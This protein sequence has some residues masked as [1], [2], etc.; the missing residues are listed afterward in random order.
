[1]VTMTSKITSLTI[2]YSIVYSKADQSKHQSPASLAFVR[3]IHRWP[4]NSPHKGPVT[5]RMFPFDY[6]IMYNYSH[7]LLHVYLHAAPIWTARNWKR[8]FWK[9]LVIQIC[10]SPILSSV[11]LI[12]F[13]YIRGTSHAYPDS[14]VHEANM[15][16][17]WGRQDPG[18]S[19][20]G[21]VKLA[22]WVIFIWY[23]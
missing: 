20:V 13:Y 21:H 10:Y 6:V 7:T 23:C 5:Q 16:P 12:A 9:R 2:V 15:G 17:T 22:I 4:M 1:M 3:G 8:S 14:K 18:G 11:R 19:H